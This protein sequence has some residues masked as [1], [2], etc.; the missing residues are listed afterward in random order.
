MQKDPDRGEFVGASGNVFG[1][2]NRR[3]LQ[4]RHLPG[5]LRIASEAAAS[6]DETRPA[7]LPA[8]EVTIHFRPWAWLAFPV[9]E[10]VREPEQPAA[11]I[12]EL[13][14]A[15]ARR[16]LSNAPFVHP[17]AAIPGRTSCRRRPAAA[18]AV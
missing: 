13:E 11:Q 2:P 15:A 16:V 8:N 12:P 17:L 5:M 14:R 4:P 10:S 1:I 3:G 18:R 6:K 9:Q 7:A